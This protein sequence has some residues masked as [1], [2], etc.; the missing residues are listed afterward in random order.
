MNNGCDFHVP[1]V[2]AVLHLSCEEDF[3]SECYLRRSSFYYNQAWEVIVIMMARGGNK[4]LPS[5]PETILIPICPFTMG[6]TDVE[7]KDLIQRYSDFDRRLFQRELPQ[8]TVDVS[9]YRI[10]KAPITN[11]LFAAFVKAAGYRTT[12]EEEGWGFHWPD[13]IARVEG[14]DWRHPVGP[15][16]G[17]DDKMEHPVVEVSW[18]DAVAYC[19]WLAE[20]TGKPYRLP[21]EAEWEKAARGTDGRRWPWGDEWEPMRCN[22]ERRVGTTTPVAAYSPA[23]DSPFG[24]VDMVGNVWEW[25]STTIG[26]EDP[27]PARFVYP[28]RPDDGR[29]DMSLPTRRVGRGGSWTNDEPNC[30]CAFRFADPPGERYSNEGFRVAM[31]VVE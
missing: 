18:H 27:W 5:E 16:S 2:R 25:T 26:S 24:C 9:A 10:G 20:L 28:Y 15:G 22:C 31:S 3:F 29:E 8:H 12:A 23:G 21:T 4:L 19:A 30:R 14:A 11:T 7:A 13:G 1:S 6:S 17:I